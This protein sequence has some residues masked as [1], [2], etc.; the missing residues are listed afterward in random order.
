MSNNLPRQALSPVS[1]AGSD[2]SGI[3][4]YQS[5]QSI[6]SDYYNNGADGGSPKMGPPN[7]SATFQPGGP[8]PPPIAPFRD[9]HRDSRDDGRGGHLGGAPSPPSSVA[10]SSDGAALY[11]NDPSYGSLKGI[12]VEEE[13]AI[14]HAALK[15]L[16]VQDLLNERNPQ[17]KRARDKLLRLSGV[18]FHELSTDVYDE[19]QRRQMAS[20]R[21]DSGPTPAYLPPK[22]SFHP[23][24]NQARMKLS[25]LPVPRF[26]DL[27]K[28]VFYE[29]E[30]RYPQFSDGP[31]PPL[32]P[33]GSMTSVRNFPQ[34]PGPGRIGSPGPGRIGSPGPNG[35]RNGPPQGYPVGPHGPGGPGP[36]GSNQFGRP[37]P[38]TFQSNTII[39]NKSTMVE[40]DDD[41]GGVDDDP[42]SLYGLDDNKRETRDTLP[43][44]SGPPGSSDG[45]KRESSS[46]KV[47]SRAGS[48]RS[49]NGSISGSVLT[50]IGGEADKKVIAD[51]QSQVSSLQQRLEDL[52]ITLR[53]KEAELI[54]M[55]DE[56][57]Q[58]EAS[59][60]QE[61]KEWQGDKFELESKI[62]TVETHNDSLRDEISKLKENSEA[63]ERSL[64]GQ[65]ENLKQQ[66]EDVSRQLDEG[67]SRIAATADG[68]YEVLLAKHE[69]LKAELREQ[70]EVTEEVR[71][72]A[73]EFLKE[74]KSLS[75]RSAESWERE[76]RLSQ[77]VAK[78]QDEVKDWKGR[79]ARAKTQ[80]RSIRTTSMG[81]A[82]QQSS[83]SL[84]ARDGGFTDSNGIIKDV[85]VT[86]FQIAI[87]DM[88]RAARGVD[89]T[90]A[91]EHMKT[92]VVA[93]RA[94]TRCVDEAMTSLAALENADSIAKLKSRVSAT[95]NN[96]ITAAKNH[97]TANGLS[98]VS[99]LDAAASHLT[100]S[101]VEL[102]KMVKIKPSPPAE[103]EDVAEELVKEEPPLSEHSRQQSVASS[104]PSQINRGSIRHSP[105][106]HRAATPTK[107]TPP[108]TQSTP[109][110]AVFL[111]MSTDSAYSAMSST[112]DSFRES[113]GSGVGPNGNVNW[114]KRDGLS[115][116]S[117]PRNI[118]KGPT[119]G[120][121]T[122]ENNVEEL[123]MFVENHF[124]GIV[125]SIQALLTAIRGDSD[126]SVLRKDVF[127]IADVVGKVVNS[128]Q[129][130]M[131]FTGNILLRERGQITVSKLGDCREKML[132]LAT[133]EESI[134]G[135]PGKEFKAKLAGLSFD[136]A[137]EIKELVKT[138][139]DIDY[140]ARAEVTSSMQE[141][142]LQ[143]ESDDLR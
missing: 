108:P 53:E 14:H 54:R 96:V 70:Q 128:T 82:M 130:S 143:P 12:V 83:P 24:R 123:R 27:A 21:R 15:K 40:E 92:V 91:L 56:E 46:S 129:S 80:L 89:P 26:R 11:T 38:K 121:R 34:P 141:I 9:M 2:W 32:S 109:Q 76:E 127:E 48:L 19:L 6:N 140:E 136:M 131:S 126:M 41:D 114:G 116:M 35:I 69:E 115:M 66:L 28:D 101:V 55:K 139:E 142:F 97:A 87:D 4:R 75:E 16:L 113:R 95:A 103:L 81:L 84:A 107:F 57:M 62:V 49:M 25:T 120:I 63:I 51:Y 133:Q 111:R 50:G 1:V 23:K 85:H 45:P 94:I 3:S 71:R 72:E 52:E 64:H 29:L 106:R 122:A 78:L 132:D 31:D 18:Q 8:P 86:K 61:Q 137:R 99:L 20:E 135:K 17:Q 59:I 7:R 79:Y 118:P 102:V 39:P 30:R 13:L 43:S 100:A 90:T 74:M 22:E 58:R 10:R 117:P 68:D 60:L 134:D 105:E 93:T 77:Q 37:L 125:E 5:I 33:T 73:T 47:R 124:E 67:S 36:A 119:I 65:I 88:L 110:S 112:R 42:E 138:V 98:P 44:M 104:A